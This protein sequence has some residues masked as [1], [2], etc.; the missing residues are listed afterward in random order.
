VKIVVVLVIVLEHGAGGDHDDENECDVS[1]LCGAALG[2]MGNS[3]ENVS[4]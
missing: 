2:G 3:S 4:E 1:M